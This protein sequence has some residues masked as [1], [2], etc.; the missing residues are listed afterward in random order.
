MK[1]E[2]EPA[3]SPEDLTRLFTEL[4]NA[5]DRVQAVVPGGDVSMRWFG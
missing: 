5:G 2:R 4:A 1:A 3:R